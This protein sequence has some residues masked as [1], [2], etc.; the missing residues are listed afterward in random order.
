MLASRHTGT[1]IHNHG[2]HRCCLLLSGVA[3]APLLSGEERMGCLEDLLACVSA[4]AGPATLDFL[5]WQQVSRGI[6]QAGQLHSM[7]SLYTIW[8]AVCN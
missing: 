4:F 7:A 3:D 2:P 1:H 6:G 5:S 8:Y